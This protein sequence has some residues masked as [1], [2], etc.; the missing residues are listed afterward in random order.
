MEALLPIAFSVLPDDL[1]EPLVAL[2]KFFKN[3]CANVLRDDLLMENH[4]NI[5]VILCKLET[6]FSPEFWN[7]MEHL[8]VHLAQKSSLGWFSPLSMDVPI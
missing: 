6:I 8:P 1:L 3:L 4:R 2:R 7:A 5:A